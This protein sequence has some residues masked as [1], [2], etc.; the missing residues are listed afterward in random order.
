LGARL[1]RQIAG[2]GAAAALS[3]VPAIR[4]PVPLGARRPAEETGA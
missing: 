2:S 3:P 4:P 1:V